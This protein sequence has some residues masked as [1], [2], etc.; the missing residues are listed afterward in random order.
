MYA[1]WGRGEGVGGREATASLLHEVASP[2]K[3]LCTCLYQLGMA[4][5][6]FVLPV[7]VQ[8]VPAWKYVSMGVCEYGSM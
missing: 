3:G 6:G 5:V 4:V 8:L 1:A 2:I 7:A